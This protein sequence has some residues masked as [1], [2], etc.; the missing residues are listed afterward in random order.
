MKSSTTAGY[1]ILELIVSMGLALV[2][3]AVAIANFQGTHRMVRYDIERTSLNQNLRSTL[4]ILGMN[5]RLS[6]ENLPGF[7]P[8]VLVADNGNS[9]V[10]TIRRS[11]LDEN[12]S[13]CAGVAASTT[14]PIIF[15]DTSSS[16][17]DCSYTNKGEVLL[18]W[19]N[20]RIARGGT[21]LGYLYSRNHHWGEWFEWTAETDNTTTMFITPSSGVWTNSYDALLSYAYVIEE[22]EFSL[23]GDTLQMVIDGDTAHPINVANQLT[24]FD[25][26]VERKDGGVQSAF[27]SGDDW[28]EIAVLNITLTGEE[29]S[30]GRIISRSLRGSFFPRN[31]LS[32]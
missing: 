4:D 22:W 10:L 28:G 21:G 6:G 27:T 16:E 25:V 31:V 11:V 15:A 23:N 26:S 1:T 2:V 18:S 29:S 8:A 9:D 7:F 12:L 20:S 17:P 14:Y 32:G 5:V 13:A 30:G 19:A 3:G 24:G